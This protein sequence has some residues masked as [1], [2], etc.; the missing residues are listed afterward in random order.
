MRGT[1]AGVRPLLY[2]LFV[3]GVDKQH[4]AG[5][6]VLSILRTDFFSPGRPQRQQQQ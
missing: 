2:R 6:R 3:N 4:A 1:P 5:I